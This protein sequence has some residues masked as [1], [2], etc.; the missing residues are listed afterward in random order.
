MGYTITLKSNQKITPEQFQEAI[1]KLNNFYR[2]GGV[3]GRTVCDVRLDKQENKVFVTGSFQM[4]GKHAEG[5]ALNM[6]IN[7]QTQGHVI[8]VTSSDF[9]LGNY[10]E[11]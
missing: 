5:F 2:Q 3:Y 1:N 11:E 8:T 9:E 10:K 4:S 6:L 7:L